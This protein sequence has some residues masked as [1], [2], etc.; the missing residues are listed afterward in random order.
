MSTTKKIALVTGAN[1]GIGFEI[2]KQLAMAGVSVYIG[3]RDESRGIA[4]EKK[5]SAQGLDVKALNIDLNAL[6]T[7]D[8]AVT[9]LIKEHG[10]LDILVNNAGVMSTEDGSP[11]TTDLNVVKNTF[12]TNF[13]S[14]LYVTQKFLPLLKLA[15][16]ARIVN[17][18]SGLGSLALNQ[19]PHWEYASAKLIGYNASKAALNM[20][21]VQLAWELKDTQIKVNSANPNFTNTEL[22]PDT[23]GG[24]PVEDGAKVA[25]TLA[26]LSAD[27]PSGGFFE[28]DL[29]TLLPW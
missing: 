22:L 16:A 28:D 27:G 25:V 24:R 14:A 4:A 11:Q 7:V 8:E 21:T 29:D 19:D 20:L 23:S 12:E 9:L 17:I 6:K 15:P 13:F 1:K 5:L 10:H 26:L 2:A 3:A 18:S